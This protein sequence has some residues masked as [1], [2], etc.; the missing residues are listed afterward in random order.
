MLSFKLLLIYWSDFLAELAPTVPQGRLC[1]GTKTSLRAHPDSSFE[2]K[3]EE[4]HSEFIFA[5]NIPKR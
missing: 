2:T 1:F 3:V 4:K 5:G